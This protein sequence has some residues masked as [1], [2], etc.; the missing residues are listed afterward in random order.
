MIHQKGVVVVRGVWDLLELVCMSLEFVL[1]MVVLVLLVRLLTIRLLVLMFVFI[2][3]L[4]IS[5]LESGIIAL[6]LM[7]ILGLITLIL[8]IILFFFKPARMKAEPL[9]LLKYSVSLLNLRGGYE[10]LLFLRI[11]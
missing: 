8:N 11:L 10:C 2:P 9:M 4:L 5:W 7:K 1:C 3:V 6:I